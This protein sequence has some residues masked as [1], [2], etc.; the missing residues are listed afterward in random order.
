M[1]IPDDAAWNF[2][3]I[4]H[5]Y[6]LH[7]GTDKVIGFIDKYFSLQNVERI[8]R[9]VV[10]SCHVC[11]AAKYYTRATVSV[12]YYEIPRKPKKTV[13]LDLF[14]PLPQISEGN[15]YILVLCDHFSKLT[16][17]YPIRN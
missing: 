13:S 9:D 16:K 6:L 5:R 17:L 15:K 1:V 8:A 4:V 3:N 2:T 10:S 12:Y 11:I 7:F 14:G